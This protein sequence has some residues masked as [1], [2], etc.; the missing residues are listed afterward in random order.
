MIMKSAIIIT[1]LYDGKGMNPLNL[2]PA[3]GK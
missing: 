2:P 1:C 3:M